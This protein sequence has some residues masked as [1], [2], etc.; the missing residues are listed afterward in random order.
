MTPDKFIRKAIKDGLEPVTNLLVTEEVLPIDKDIPLMH[1]QINS[2]SRSR[3]AVSKQN[4]EWLASV[5]L[6]IVRV[7]KKGY[8]SSA[9]MDDVDSEIVRFMDSIV[10]PGF[11]VNFSRFSM[12]HTD[13][14]ESP[15]N[16]IN[17]KHVIY[18]MWLNRI[19]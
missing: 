3:T 1:I 5:T 9:E 19:L 10:V 14:V 17:R 16:T 12:S 8:I 11:R 15:A 6:T 2:Q 4:Y 18:E 13:N 7:N